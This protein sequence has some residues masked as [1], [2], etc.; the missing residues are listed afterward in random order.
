MV[1]ASASST[2]TRMNVAGA[3]VHLC[4][5]AGV[6]WAIIHSTCVQKA[7]RA[8]G[9]AK[10]RRDESL[11]LDP[12]PLPRLREGRRPRNDPH[13]DCKG[14]CRCLLRNILQLPHAVHRPRAQELFPLRRRLLR[15]MCRQH[16]RAGPWPPQLRPKSGYLRTPL[17]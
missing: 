3:I 15:R 11:L 13:S 1:A 2:T 5:A 4:I 6:A 9:K 7:R 12:R 17:S 8:K 10:A 16:F 14:H